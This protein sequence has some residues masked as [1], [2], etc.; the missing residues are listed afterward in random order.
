MESDGQMTSVIGIIG[1]NCRSD[2]HRT[3]LNEM[4]ASA[5]GKALQ[6]KITS[7]ASYSSF[8]SAVLAAD[9]YLT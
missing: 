8:R 5:H 3:Q 7:G 9:D 1:Q 6:N 2:I 4:R